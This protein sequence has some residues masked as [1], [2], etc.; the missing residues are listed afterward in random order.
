MI[1]LKKRYNN[2][3]KVATPVIIA[4]VL[5][6]LF[7]ARAFAQ[8]EGRISTDTI[9]EIQTADPVAARRLKH[10]EEF[11]YGAFAS[12]ESNYLWRGLNFG[13][14]SL[15]G[16]ANISYWG[17]YLDMWWNLG[18]PYYGFKAFQP[19]V[20]LTFG[21][22]RWGLDICAM[23]VYNFNKGFFDFSNY[24]PGSGGNGLEVRGRYTVSDKIPLSFLWATKVSAKDGYYDESGELKRAWST[25]IEVSYTH[26]FKNGL[27]LYGA[28]GMTPWRSIYT[29]YYGGAMVNNIDLRCWKKW[30]VS[31]HCGIQLTGQLMLNPYFMTDRT[32]A[33]AVY[34]HHQLGSPQLN[35]NIGVKVFLIK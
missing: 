19:E 26:T 5:P 24:P 29:Y 13:G 14:L 31:K 1:A 35:G 3:W 2:F 30:V 22:R 11:S 20:D 28:V 8:E 10:K 34:S 9:T 18:V 4:G 23:Y 25:Y 21:F 17:V 32:A 12:I 7:S 6:F 33:E 16:S 15:Q 27:S